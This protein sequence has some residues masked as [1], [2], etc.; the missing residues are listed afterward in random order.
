MPKYWSR[1][2]LRVCAYPISLRGG[3]AKDI[4]PCC[5]QMEDAHRVVADRRLESLS[6][7]EQVDYGCYG[8]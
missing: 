4:E 1:K 6:V 2:I 5:R 7:K 3:L 8:I